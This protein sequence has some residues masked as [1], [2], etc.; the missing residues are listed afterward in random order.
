MQTYRNLCSENDLF[1]FEI[2]AAGT[3]FQAGSDTQTALEVL[4]DGDQ[5][6]IFRNIFTNVLHW[7]FVSLPAIPGIGVYSTEHVRV[8]W[9]DS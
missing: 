6:M 8:S 9:E 5:W 4:V 3:Q 2:E 1:D 7:D